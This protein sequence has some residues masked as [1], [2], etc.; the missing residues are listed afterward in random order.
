MSLPSAVTSHHSAWLA[1]PGAVPHVVRYVTEGEQ[2]ICFGDGVLRDVPDGAPVT[3][4]IHE[5]AGG[6][7]L[8]T[9]G[10]RVGTI[11]PEQ[12]STS[13]L[14]ELLDH[15]P[16]GRSMDEVGRGL[17]RARAER[18]VVGLRVQGASTG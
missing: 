2:L 9:F 15:V 4:S 11:P 10:A 8:A 13:A 18:R 7:L 14:A 17:D 5:I 6:R 1:P 12:V 3:V 16:L